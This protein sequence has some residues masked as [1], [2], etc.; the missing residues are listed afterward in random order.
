MNNGITTIKLYENIES[1]GLDSPILAIL[2]SITMNNH[3]E[4]IKI[5]INRLLP[6]YLQ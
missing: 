1:P 6:A 3:I 4:R 2:I 5:D